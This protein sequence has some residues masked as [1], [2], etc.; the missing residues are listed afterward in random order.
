MSSYFNSSSSQIHSGNLD[1][2]NSE[3]GFLILKNGQ[4]ID[5]FVSTH[6]H[7]NFGHKNIKITASIKEQLGQLTNAA[8][9]WDFD[10]KESVS[11]QLKR[12]LGFA[13]GKIFYTASGS[14][15]MENALKIARQF[16][17]KNKILAR[18]N[19]YHGDT[20]G[21]LSVTGDW[22]NKAHKTLSDWTVRIP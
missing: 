1:A 15:A 4:K 16:T 7:T 20:L 8:P 10:L 6:F 3:G 21:A 14:E 12:L 2:A 18:H 11:S 19:S 5:D 22:R 9:E 13:S 17:G